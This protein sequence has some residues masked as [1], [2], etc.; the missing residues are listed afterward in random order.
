VTE[1]LL[2]IRTYRLLPAT[3]DA[4]HQ[5]FLEQARPLLQEFGVDVVRGAPSEQNEVGEESYVLLR[6]F[7]SLEQRDEQEQR[8]YGSQ[9]WRDGPREPV[10]SKIESYHTVVLT[11]PAD[12][13][14]G[15][16]S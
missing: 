3:T 16:R 11:L 7:D 14:D 5:V 8:F 2:E 9:Q 10:L 4:F 6:A 15:M 13:I 1:R 12:V